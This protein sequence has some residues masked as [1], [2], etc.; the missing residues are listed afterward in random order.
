MI[1][2][3]DTETTGF[4][5]PTLP[6]DHP[7]QPHLVQMGI[8]LCT[9][10]GDEVASVDLT[11]RPEGYMI[12]EPAARTHGITTEIAL[13]TGIPLANVMG[14]F[15]QMR[16]LAHEAVA[17]NS[18]FDELVV[19]AA[20]ARLG[21]QPSSPGPDKRTCCMELAAPIMELPP[22]ARMKAAG[23]DKFKPPS[24][25]EAHLFFL[26]YEFQGAHSAVV[27]ARATQ[28]VHQVLRMLEAYNP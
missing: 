17:F 12:P 5:Q 23:F 13:Q 6:P 20:F 4:V 8:V 7:T 21:R 18:K 10:L 28:R 22:T 15:A 9:D 19:A 16:A 27:D 24:L 26:G 2:Y 25:K 3:W 1:I 11:V 14:I